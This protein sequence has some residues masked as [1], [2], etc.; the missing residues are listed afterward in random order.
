MIKPLL[1]SLLFLPLLSCAPSPSV[2][3]RDGFAPG[4]DASAVFILPFT[5]IMVPEEVSDLVFD[6]F[7][8]LLNESP[9]GARSEFI[10]LKEGLSSLPAGALEGHAYVTG[11]VFGYLEESGCCSTEISFRARIR[12]H[13]PGRAEPTLLISYPAASFFDH[14]S[15]SPEAERVRLSQR[16]ASELA[17]RLLQALSGP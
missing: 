4:L 15:S 16:A 1:L 5:S 3:R 11:E 10:I 13:Q 12:L 9:Q 14:D 6:R 17:A 7:V 8:D 2:E